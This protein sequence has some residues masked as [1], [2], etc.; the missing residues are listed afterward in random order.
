[1]VNDG[2][3]IVS[4]SVS[5]SGLGGVGKS[6]LARKY[7][8]Q[9]SKDYYNKVI[10]INAENYNTLS[11]S[12]RRLA[13]DKLGISLKNRDGKEKDIKSI[14]E[15]VYSFFSKGKSL[16][17]FDNAEKYRSQREDDDGIDKFLPSLPE[18]M[19]K[20]YILVTSRNK[21]WPQNVKLLEL[22]VFT[23]EEA[24]EFIK[25][26][27]GNEQIENEEDVI[28]LAETLQ[29]FPLA[30]QQAVAYIKVK[31]EELKNVDSG[32]SVDDYLKRYEEKT[33]E[34]LNF[35]FPEDSD[36]TYTKTTLTTWKI[37][38]D[39]IKQIENGDKAIEIMN[40]I[41]YF[42]PDNISIKMFLALL[43]I[44]KS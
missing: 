19:N 13:C 40:I 14:V 6:E 26:S 20:P 28:K 36:N 2:R 30:L 23:K 42:A 11:E 43:R 32:F 37:T 34:L 3:A 22:D 44:K 17:V 35:Q 31:N 15:D 1:M 7:I 18:N 38:L 29:Y 39:S 33:T 9:Y 25:K 12:F 10:W 8:S 4:Q 21:K 24:I 27:L 16:F 41:A 5:I